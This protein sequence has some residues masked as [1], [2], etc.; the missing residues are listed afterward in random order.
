MDYAP[1]PSHSPRS[2]KWTI[3]GAQHAGSIAD[4][5]YYK[6]S[7]DLIEDPTKVPD[8]EKRLQRASD[9][10]RR[11]V[12]KKY[13]LPG[14]WEPADNLGLDGQQHDREHL[15]ITGPNQGDDSLAALNECL[16]SRTGNWLLQGCMPV[17]P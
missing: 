16:T 10:A 14:N 11:T 4:I 6:V 2:E 15:Q 17:R 5:E 8:P 7:N 9:A 1:D 3:I 13:H 12:I